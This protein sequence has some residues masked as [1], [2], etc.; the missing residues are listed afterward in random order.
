MQLNTVAVV[1]AGKMGG[2]LAQML[3]TEAVQVLLKGILGGG[4]PAPKPPPSAPPGDQGE[5]TP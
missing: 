5:S 1:G 2:G 4:Q 3:A